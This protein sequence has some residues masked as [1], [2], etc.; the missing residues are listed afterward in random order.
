[1]GLATLLFRLNGRVRR[2]MKVLKLS[3]GLQFGSFSGL[4]QA[5]SRGK[6]IIMKM[7]RSCRCKRES[8]L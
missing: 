2:K 5:R 6:K 1:M 8:T 4:T 3:F 7:T